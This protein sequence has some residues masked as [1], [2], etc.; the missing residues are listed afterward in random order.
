VGAAFAFA[1]DDSVPVGEVSLAES[2]KVRV[3]LLPEILV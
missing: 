2:A 1:C 3:V